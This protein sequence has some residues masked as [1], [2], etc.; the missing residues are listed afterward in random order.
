MVFC[1]QKKRGLSGGESG[2]DVQAVQRAVYHALELEG[3]T[4]QNAR[5][6]TYGDF[7]VLDVQA[8]QRLEGIEATGKT[9]QP[10]LAA[11]WPSVDAYGA[12]LYFKARIGAAPAL[13]AGGLWYGMNGSRVRALQQMLWRA[14]GSSSRNIRNGVFGDGVADD[15]ELFY[16]IADL[17]G[18]DPSTVSPDQWAMLYG[19]ADDYARDL[20]AES[21]PAGSSSVRSD[22]VTWAEWY[23]STGGSYAQLRPYQRDEP[24]RTPLVNDCSGSIH[25]LFKLSGGP[26]PSGNDFDGSGYTGTMEG[27]GTRRDLEAAPAAGDCVF[28]GGAE[29]SGTGSTHVAMHLGDGRIFTFGSN[30]PTITSFSGYWTS[31]RR[32]DIG[33]RRY[34]S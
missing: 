2:K 5:N 32:S 27:R 13:P 16:A 24:P 19:F 31:G 14:L 34:F 29:G 28:Y 26:D 17:D 25:H 1:P 7:T 8:F 12:S 22:L 6:G 4:P 9:G 20:A 15:L 3:V 11:L 18:A 23:V 21:A 33:A 30:P 10:T